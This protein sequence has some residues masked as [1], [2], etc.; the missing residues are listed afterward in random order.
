[1]L[2]EKRQQP[3]WLDRRVMRGVHQSWLRCAA[4]YGGKG[5]AVLVVAIAISLRRR[6]EKP[7]TYSIRLEI[8]EAREGDTGQKSAAGTVATSA[9]LFLHFGRRQEY[10]CDP[11]P[12]TCA[13]PGL[14]QDP[15]REKSRAGEG[16]K[17]VGTTE[18]DTAPALGQPRKPSP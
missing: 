13:G 6:G 8:K 16:Q 17:S 4:L 3:E 14:P 9:P 2:L 7:A 18:K 11:P 10:D 12:G 1:M 5:K 15:R